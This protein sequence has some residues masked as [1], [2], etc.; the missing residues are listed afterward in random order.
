MDLF[1][2]YDFPFDKG[3]GE[4]SQEDV[5]FNPSNIGLRGPPFNFSGGWSFVA[6]KLFISTRLDGT[7][8]RSNF[9]TCL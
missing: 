6:D 7:L 9:V 4:S 3:G 8:N 5:H 1:T 2:K